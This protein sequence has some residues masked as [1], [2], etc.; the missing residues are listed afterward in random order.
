MQPNGQFYV[1]LNS[2]IGKGKLISAVFYGKA[3]G[4]PLFFVTPPVMNNVS[5][6]GGW[7][8]RLLSIDSKLTTTIKSGSIVRVFYM[9]E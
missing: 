1:D 7:Y 3:E 2:F 8:C 6:D 5:D 9:P 4:S